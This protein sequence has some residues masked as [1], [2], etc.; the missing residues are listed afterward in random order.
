MEWGNLMENRPD[1][2]N[3]TR[4]IDAIPHRIY[5]PLSEPQRPF[6]NGQRYYHCM[7]TQLVIDNQGNISFIQAGLLGS[8]HD[9]YSYRL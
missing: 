5:R 1:F 7:K 6:Y 8:T 4:A 3:V 9:A 2:H